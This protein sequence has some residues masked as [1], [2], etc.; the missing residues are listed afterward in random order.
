MGNKHEVTSTQ[1]GKLTFTMCTKNG[2]TVGKVKFNNVALVKNGYNLFSLTLMQLKGWTLHG[3]DKGI[4]LQKGNQKLV[5]D[6]PQHQLG[7]SCKHKCVGLMFS[8]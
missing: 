8:L 3:N 2:E 6:M 5:F 1:V 4:W 7:M